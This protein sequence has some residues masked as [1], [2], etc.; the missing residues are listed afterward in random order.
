MQ[1]L[2]LRSGLQMTMRDL[3]QSA[4]AVTR[5]QMS[6]R[7]VE[8]IAEVVAP[9][10]SVVSQVFAVNGQWVS[11]GDELLVMDGDETA[12]IQAYLPP[13]DLKYAQVGQKATI[14]FQSGEEF[15]AVV[16]QVS[17]EAKRG[18]TSS[19]NDGLK[20]S[21]TALVVKLQPLVD[22]PVSLRVNNLPVGV[23]FV[24]DSWF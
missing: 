21:S 17:K 9:L 5:Q 20:S 7:S 1:L 11:A 6:G 22:L 4:S 13:E 2:E 8:S 15:E 19:G 3:R 24:S 18:P 10:V 12:W 23:H 16:Q 14:S